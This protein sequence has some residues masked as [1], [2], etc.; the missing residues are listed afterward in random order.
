M[1]G[2]VEAEGILTV[3]GHSGDIDTNIFRFGLT[4][5]ILYSMT[6]RISRYS[7]L[8]EAE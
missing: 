5:Y 6:H 2:L 4:P 8:M 1:I 3:Y 7:A